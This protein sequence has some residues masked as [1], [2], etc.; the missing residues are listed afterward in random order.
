MEM[1]DGSRRL[2]R[3]EWESSGC[4]EDDGCG[5]DAGL[6]RQHTM[7]QFLREKVTGLRR[8]ALFLAVALLL[9]FTV[10]L[11]LLI[12]VV[13]GGPERQPI[14]DSQDISARQH[15]HEDFKNPSAMLTAPTGNITNG[16]YLEWETMT[17]NTFCHGGFNYSNG[18]LVVPRNGIY[19]VFLQITYQRKGDPWCD[20][21]DEMTLRNTV[22]VYRETYTKYMPLLSSVD[23]V[24]CSMTKWTKSLYAAGLFSLEANCRLTVTSSHPQLI[25]QKESEMFFGAELLP[26]LSGQAAVIT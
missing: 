20:H 1:L 4:M 9:L 14:S 12:V 8:L 19:R 7:I 23:T 15:Q 18:V 10:A 17:G 6:H 22:F 21:S 3:H 5:K 2:I 13:H 26:Q 24:S 25:V 11:A 16:E